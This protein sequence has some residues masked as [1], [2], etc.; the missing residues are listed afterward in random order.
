AICK[1]LSVVH[2]NTGAPA[3]PGLNYNGGEISGVTV[4]VSD[5]VPASTMVM[6]DASQVAAA[7]E[8]ITLDASNEATIQL[9][10]P[11]DSPPSGSSPLT[12]LWQ[13]NMTGLRAERFFGCNRLNTTA[14]AMVTGV[15]VL[16]DSPGP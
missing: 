13:M 14:V 9:D 7:S 16:G 11:P 10:S 12:S 4:L 15:N 8:T 2:T 6:V 3:F 5:G 1:A